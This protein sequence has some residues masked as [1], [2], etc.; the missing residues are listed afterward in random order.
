[1]L[2]LPADYAQTSET[3]Q[4]KEVAARRLLEHCIEQLASASV[5]DPDWIEA[6][7]L[8]GQIDPAFAPL[9]LEALADDRYQVCRALAVS[10]S[11]I[12]PP[13]FYDVIAALRHDHPNVRQFAAGLLY[14][15]AQRD[16]PIRDAVPALAVALQDPDC[17]VRHKTAVT[18]ERIGREAEAAVPNLIEA[19]S[20]EDDFVREWAAHALG[21]IG[22][23]AAQAIPALTEALLDEEPC[24]QQAA[25]EALRSC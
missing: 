24:V 15:L 12:G 6:C 4:K 16:V 21:A 10:L 7:R 25:R 18:L 22:P 3:E 1:M 23:A 19:L 9:Q 5:G 17:R 2:S 14:G 13:V 20:D 11:R 8:L